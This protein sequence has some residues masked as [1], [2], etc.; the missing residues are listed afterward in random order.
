MNVC[1]NHIGNEDSVYLDDVLWYNGKAVIYVWNTRNEELFEFR[2]S[3]G[4]VIP[5]SI[6]MEDCFHSYME[7]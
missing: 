3:K 1:T 4:A 2:S 7:R 6:K 5:I